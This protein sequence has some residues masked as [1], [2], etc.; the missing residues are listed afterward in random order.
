MFTFGLSASRAPCVGL[1]ACLRTKR[2]FGHR[3]GVGQQQLP[4]ALTDQHGWASPPAVHIMAAGT[5]SPSTERAA[6]LL[7]EASRQPG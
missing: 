6:S 5:V 1:V 7:Y 2:R 4:F 3:E